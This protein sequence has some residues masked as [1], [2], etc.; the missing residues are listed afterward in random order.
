MKTET[1][2][3]STRR[4]AHKYVTRHLKNWCTERY[5]DGK[6][7]CV[8]KPALEYVSGAKYWYRNGK[9]HRTDGPAIESSDGS[10]AWIRNGQ[11]H[12]EDGPAIIHAD[13]S[14]L[15]CLYDEQLTKR[16]FQ[17]ATQ[18]VK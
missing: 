12:R 10:K 7:H 4:R 16:Q 6:L 9:L 15:F 17:K 3:P 1:Q 5:R 13:G 11:Y 2:K 18:R 8:S 14:V